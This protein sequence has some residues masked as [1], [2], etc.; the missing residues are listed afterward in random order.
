MKVQLLDEHQEVVLDSQVDECTEIEGFSDAEIPITL[1]L[2]TS[3]APGRYEVKFLL[4]AH[5]L[6]CVSLYHVSSRLVK[7]VTSADG[8]QAVLPIRKLERGIYLLH[9][10][11]GGGRHT[12]N[13]IVWVKQVDDLLAI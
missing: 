3:L 2:S 1:S 6:G 8:H 13:D 11:C 4:S 5:N 7:R 10:E 9:I 12:Y